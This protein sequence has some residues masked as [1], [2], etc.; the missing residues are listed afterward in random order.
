MR[1]EPLTA[2]L[3]AL[4]REALR[5]VDPLRVFELASTL[6]RLH[7]VQGGDELV[8][9]AELVKQF[10]DEVG[11]EARLELLTGPL[12]LWEAYGF[13][14]PRGWRLAG[15]RVE[16]QVG[17]A[18]ET[19][20]STDETPLVAMV[21]SPPGSVEAVARLARPHTSEAGTAGGGVALTAEPAWEGYY[22]LAERYDALVGFHTGPG[23]RY[24]GIY[25][26]P[27]LEPPLAPAASIP[28][29][30]ALRLHGERVRVTVEAE[31][32]QPRTPVLV[33][34]I[35]ARGGPQL[36]L[37]AH[38]C[39]PR[40]GA[41][42]NASGTA[43]AAET[44]A[45]LAAWEKQLEE[46]GVGVTVLLAPEWTGPA[47]AARLG[48][49]DPA[50]VAAALSLDMVGADPAKTGAT[51]RVAASP[52][53]LANPLAA[54]IQHALAEALNTPVPMEP[55]TWGSDHD[56]PLAHGAPASL[57]YE[58][59][60]H[61]YHT[62]LDTPDHLDPHRL[63]A[64]ATAAA[65]AALYTA[66]NPRRAAQAAAEALKT[67]LAASLLDNPQAAEA[68][69]ETAKTTEAHAATLA[70][71]LEKGEQPTH[72]WSHDIDPEVRPP[73]TR[74]YIHLHLPE[75]H[76]TRLLRDQKHRSNTRLLATLYTATMNTE[77][78]ETAYTTLTGHKPTPQEKEDAQTL[79]RRHP[80]QR[81]RS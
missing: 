28:G 10:L 8:V 53:P 4:V 80:P 35:G 30:K 62:S 58:W 7:R 78:A 24:W 26:P 39:H 70:A 77:I 6:S 17:G 32:T 1:L 76:R 31:Y 18:W 11:V 14:E 56:I 73:Y 19:V 74:A 40:P 49:V 37:L 51:L 9:A 65:A 67:Q 36:L 41:H 66:L 71:T 20:A 75:P 52:P 21:H 15:A 38:I 2:S 34:N 54:T 57:V 29:E 44:A 42:D 59:P 22:L 16:I 50:T 13:W 69:Q 5:R 81:R 43:A 46:A 25:P 3:S 45:A 61:Y 48:I 79:L 12:G 63:A 23:V 33:A 68:A 64:T 55:Y 72:P 60:D 47:T 27:H